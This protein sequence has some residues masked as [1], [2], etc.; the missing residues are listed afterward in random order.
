M[1]TVRLHLN[2]YGVGCGWSEIHAGPCFYSKHTNAKHSVPT[3]RKAAITN[4]LAPPGKVLILSP[5][6][7][8]ENFQMKKARSN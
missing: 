6:L 8:L 5:G 7:G 3:S 1:R 4:P 2:R